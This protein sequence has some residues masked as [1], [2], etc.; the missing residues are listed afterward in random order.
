MEG[1]KATGLV[2]NPSD[3][4]FVAENPTL[5]IQPF[6]TF[7]GKIEINGQIVE[8]QTVGEGQDAK[9]FEAS[10]VGFT[11]KDVSEQDLAEIQEHYNAIVA[12]CKLIV[13][14]RFKALNPT[15]NFTY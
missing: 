1:I 7:A 2:R 12:K 14:D 5:E 15:A 13:A 8:H 10:R 4:N 3:K 6:L 11:I 9:T